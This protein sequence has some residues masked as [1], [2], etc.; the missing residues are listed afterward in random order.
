MDSEDYR[1]CPACNRRVGVV[2]VQ[3]AVPERNVRDELLVF[4]ALIGIITC[5][6][7][8]IPF[9]YARATNPVI[10]AVPE[11]TRCPICLG[12]TSPAEEEPRTTGPADP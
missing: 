3:K 1:W 5:G 2:I 8:A 6:V 7:G 12:P 10:P 4:G 11:K 9:F